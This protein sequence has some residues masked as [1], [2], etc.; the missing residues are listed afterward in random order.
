MQAAQAQQQLQNQLVGS[1]VE[2]AKSTS[3]SNLALSKERFTRA[4][5]NMGLE[6]ERAAKAVQDRAKSTLDN[7]KA[8]QEIQNISQ[9]QLMKA[10]QIVKFL[11]AYNRTQEEQ[12]K[13][14]DISISAQAE[15]PQQPAANEMLAQQLAQQT[16]P[17]GGML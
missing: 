15:Q 13:D 8:A 1:Q 16:P 10:L 5:A 17:Q 9:D 4:V 14:D 6:D 12:I 11:D 2:L 7:I 3:I